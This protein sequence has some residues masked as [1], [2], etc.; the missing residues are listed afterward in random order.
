MTL[1]DDWL[2]DIRSLAPLLTLRAPSGTDL[3]IFL[4]RIPLFEFQKGAVKRS[5]MDRK[6]FYL[7]LSSPF[8]TQKSR[9][10][11]SIFSCE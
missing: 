11:L 5:L 3:K 4:K 6:L 8:L 1:A 7:S 9:D 2:I 10:A